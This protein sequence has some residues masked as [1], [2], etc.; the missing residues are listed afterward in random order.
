M[1]HILYSVCVYMPPLCPKYIQLYAVHIITYTQIRVD[2]QL[3]NRIIY[4]MNDGV[5]LNCAEI[6]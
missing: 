5:W 2:L 6:C 3:G 4:C 1:C